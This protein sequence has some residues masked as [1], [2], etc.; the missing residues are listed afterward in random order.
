[1]KLRPYQKELYDLVRSTNKH[2]LAVSPAGCLVGDTIIQINNRGNSKKITLENAYKRWNG[3]E[4]HKSYNWRYKDNVYTRSKIGDRIGLNKVED[5]VYSGVKDVYKMT[6]ADGKMVVGTF[7][8]KIWTDK[9]WVELGN[10]QGY[11]VAIDATPLPVKTSV[12]KRERYVELNNFK[13]RK[14][15]YARVQM[16]K[17]NNGKS[18][19]SIRLELHRV[20][21]E[22]HYNGFD[23]IYSYIEAIHNGEKLKFINPKEY[24]IHHKDGNSQNNSID[25]LEML[26]V[27]E[28]KMAHAEE[29]KKN[30]GQGSIDFVECIS[31][32]YIGK[33]K[34]YDI[35]CKAPHHSFVANGVVVHNSG[36]SVVMSELVDYYSK[37][38]SVLF[39]VH[40]NNLLDQFS[41]HLSRYD[42]IHCDVMSPMRALR[43]PKNY[44]IIFI[45]E[46]HHATSKTFQDVFDKYPNARRIGF[47]ATP[48][49]LSG[50]RL[51][52]PINK[53][54]SAPFEEV[55]QTIT[56]RELVAQKFL[57]DFDIKAVDY[58]LFFEA[59]TIKAMAG[60]YSSKSIGEAFKE[61][62]L[63]ETVKSFLELA[64]GRKT[65]AYTPTITMAEK[66]AEEL[67][68]QGVVAKA[69][70]SKLSSKQVDD[71]IEQFKKSEIE[72]CVNVDLFGEGFDVPD[73]DCVWM[74]RPTKS[75]SLYIQQFMRCMRIDPKNPSK[76]ALIID[77]ANNSKT[78]GGLYTAEMRMK[79]KQSDQLLKICP[80]CDTLNYAKSRR[81][82]NPECGHKWESQGGG[83]QKK[84]PEEVKLAIKMSV[85][86]YAVSDEIMAIAKIDS[87]TITDITTK[88]IHRLC[89]IQASRHN[90]AIKSKWEQESKIP[91]YAHVKDL[92]PDI[93]VINLAC[94]QFGFKKY[95]LEFFREA[96]RAYQDW[97][98]KLKEKQAIEKKKTDNLANYYRKQLENPTIPLTIKQKYQGWLK[99][100]EE[101]L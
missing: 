9:G 52:K 12:K 96:Y 48:I 92:K 6:L 27:Y 56:I 68:K 35:C 80:A 79:L 101:N 18:I 73:C 98:K 66:L 40:R 4:K 94:E 29:N 8:H 14:H 13:L 83:L 15:P 28:H 76:R 38:H 31:V 42:N 89:M 16:D 55:F 49:R 100:Y 33:Q 72:V 36:K 91:M 34:T 75:L 81:C 85:V 41:N 78:H 65:I 67:N 64:K 1:M 82:D 87:K 11:R 10:S 26:T 51:A 69:F 5:I 39:M 17:R 58:T 53:F 63:P 22:A 74:L 7:D 2:T 54:Q 84:E 37:K 93:D 62:K 30:F 20:I 32:E 21:Y 59:K 99:D 60:E 25:N 77:F 45:D 97:E 70:H 61:D 88:F 71:Y 47:T 86:D 46:T 44:D 19:R 23:D 24:H 43:S 3:L 90:K 50:E 95:D 57:A